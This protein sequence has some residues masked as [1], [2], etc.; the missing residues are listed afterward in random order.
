MH[1]SA[2]YDEKWGENEIDY[3]LFIK[4][5]DN[6]PYDLNPE[7]VSH[8]KYVTPEEMESMLRKAEECKRKEAISESG[9][10]ASDPDGSDFVKFSPWYQRIYDNFLK[11]WWHDMDGV[12]AGKYDD[13]QKI[14]RL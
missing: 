9:A 5:T 13:Y 12:F 7:E 2:P 10:A 8:V 6:V 14:H 3:L 4:K 11:K 1:Y